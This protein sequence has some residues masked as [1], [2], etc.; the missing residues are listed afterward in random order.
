MGDKVIYGPVDSRRLGKS[1]GINLSPLDRKICSFDCV[2]CSGGPTKLKTLR[3][4]PEDTFSLDY[5]KQ[6]LERGFKYHKQNRTRIDYFSVVGATEPT[7]YPQFPEFVNL[8]FLLL[9]RYFPHKP[10]A[11]FTNCTTLGEKLIRKSIQTF[12]RAFFKLDAGDEETFHKINRAGDNI[13]L[14]DIIENLTKAQNIELSIGVID[15]FNG[16]YSSLQSNFFIDIIRRIRPIR[17]YV[18]DMDRPI[19]TKNG[20]KLMRTNEERL[21]KLA[22]KI[23]GNTGIETTVLRAKKSRGIHEL[24]KSLYS[25]Q[26]RCFL[27]G[28]DKKTKPKKPH[29]CQYL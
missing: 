17:I 8:F 1:L 13:H 9:N 28:K 2:Y 23:S 4:R 11:I 21:I 12:D 27:I 25:Y 14:K 10:S 29:L 26:H 15:T 18:Y 24:V 5:I 22:D 19:P 7:I 16:N 20:F 6:E 3:V